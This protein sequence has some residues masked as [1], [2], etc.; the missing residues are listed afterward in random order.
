MNNKNL[1]IYIIIVASIL[2]FIVAFS[3]SA[4]A[5][6]IPSIANSLNLNNIIQNWV[7]TVFLLTIAIFSLPAG[8]LVQKHGIK[9]FMI[10]GIII[11]IF[12][13]LGCIFS[14]S[15]YCLLFF[16]IIQGIGCAFINVTTTLIVVE[17]LPIEKRG[18]ALGISISAVYV[19]LTLA[20]LIAGYLNYF[21]GW[22]SV[23]FIDI[24]FLILAL[25]ILLIF[26][27]DEWKI[28]INSID[29]KGSIIF[30]I[31]MVLF[32]Y[33]FTIL[34]QL[35]GFILVFLGIIF[36]LIFVFIER[37]INEPILDIHLFKNKKFFISTLAC[38]ISYIATFVV[39][40]ILN[41][42]FT[43]VLGYNSKLTGLILIITPICTAI[44]T[45]IAG[46]LSDSYD[47][48][49][50]YTVGLIIVAFALFM[51]SN[52]GAETP[53]SLFIFIM[54]LEGIGFGLFSS[55]NVN[56]IMSSVDQKDSSQASAVVSLSRVVGQTLSL[57]IFTL[58]FAYVMGD[59]I[60]DFTNFHLLITS[61]NIVAIIS[62]VLCI[63]AILISFSIF[64]Q[65]KFFK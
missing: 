26:I 46:I 63:M 22:K 7:A 32:I 1:T 29:L 4:I 43:Y 57:G 54:C 52:I 49:K 11:T 19:G 3:N 44:V 6:T 18:K 8:R 17:A 61:S 31:A 12:G 37:K 9:F 34:N 36:F 62:C 50:I 59:V 16:R 39:T 25:L 56:T 23:F 48:I 28:P 40:F 60:L 13:T 27:K 20:P 35:T 15:P 45:P 2:N 42:H 10:F 51:L 53:F 21:G 64:K 47:S 41:Y 65:K 38:L 55:P 58:V 30:A 33:G 14:F 5:I 24:P